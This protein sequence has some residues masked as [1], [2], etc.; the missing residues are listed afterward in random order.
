MRRISWI[1]AGLYLAGGLAVWIS[2]VH[3]N[4]DGL[5]NVGLILYVAPISA[6]GI[7]LGKWFDGGQFPLIPDAFGYITDH[8][9]FYFPSLLLVAG[10]IR[11]T[12][13]WI[14]RLAN[15]R[16]LRDRESGNKDRP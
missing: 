9:L 6:A 7:L 5:A 16:K 13:E 2:F 12:G 15:V 11:L 3:T 14:V 10:L 4:P 1:L 8:A